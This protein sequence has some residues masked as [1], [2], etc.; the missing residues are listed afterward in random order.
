MILLFFLAGAA[1]LSRIHKPEFASQYCC[2][3]PTPPETASTYKVAAIMS[4]SSRPRDD[5]R[6]DVSCSHG[7]NQWL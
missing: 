3:A 4:R 5:S 1:N 7:M 2:S 6:T